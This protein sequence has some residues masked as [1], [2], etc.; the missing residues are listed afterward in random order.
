MVFSPPSIRPVIIAVTLQRYTKFPRGGHFAAQPTTGK[1]D[2]LT[3]V[4]N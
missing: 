4:L 1:Q 3:F 2:H